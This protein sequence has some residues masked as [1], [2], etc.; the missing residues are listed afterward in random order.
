MRL[1]SWPLHHH[2]RE[3]DSPVGLPR[4]RAR[5]YC[6]GFDS[7]SGHL[8]DLSDRDRR[9]AG[10]IDVPEADMVELV[11]RAMPAHLGT[12]R[13]GAVPVQV[14]AVLPNVDGQAHQV[15]RIADK[16]YRSFLSVDHHVQPLSHGAVPPA[17]ARSGLERFGFTGTHPPQRLEWS[18]IGLE[19]KRHG[20]RVTLGKA[21]VWLRG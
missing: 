12:V 8:P 1:R 17:F 4:S 18:L 21:S 15:V 13:P 14:C 10:E 16:G 5:S 20:F 3:I 19:P 2:G 6:C 9:D 7:P 11:E